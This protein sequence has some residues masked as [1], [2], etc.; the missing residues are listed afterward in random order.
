MRGGLKPQGYTII[1]TLIFLAISGVMFTLIVQGISGQQERT[2]FST[3]IREMESRLR[4]TMNDVSTGYYPISSNN[5]RCIQA[6]N[7]PQL[8]NAPSEQGT[9]QDCTYIGRVIKFEQY[10]S[11][12]Q[13]YYT[14]SVVGLR[15]VAGQEVQ[16]MT[17]AAPT[18][19]AMGGGPTYTDQ[20]ELLTIPNTVELK[21]MKYRNGALQDVGAFGVF[22]TFSTVSTTGG[23]K[24]GSGN[25]DLYPVPGSFSDSIQT[26]G[27]SV[28][29]LNSGSF[30]NPP[31][32]LIL[33]F[34][35]GGPNQYGII[36]IGGSGGTTA[37]ISEVKTNVDKCTYEATQI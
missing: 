1:E 5:L 15:R 18:V 16:N 19:L 11:D 33:C 12:R 27:A 21:W 6:G 8:N 13:V 32:G 20:M 3:A 10:G 4:D 14:M 29:A 35:G 9:N 25:I 34:E 37:T 26:A 31:N 17:Q 24:S 2:Q 28:E 23:L 36:R 7:R 30:K 22:T